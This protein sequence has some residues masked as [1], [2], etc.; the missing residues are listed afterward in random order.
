[1]CKLK[2]LVE[3]EFSQ[4]NWDGRHF[5]INFTK[6]RIPQHPY[7]AS[8]QKLQENE[9]ITFEIQHISLMHKSGVII[10][11]KEVA[12]QSWSTFRRRVVSMSWS[13]SL[14]PTSVAPSRA[15]PRSLCLFSAT[16]QHH[17]RGIRTL[18]HSK[19]TSLLESHR[20]RWCDRGPWTQPSHLP[21]RLVFSEL[22]SSLG[23]MLRILDTDQP[24]W[25]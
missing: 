7:L 9:A 16:Q 19:T 21:Q 3:N 4:V 15:Q 5:Y 22:Q 14:H 20:S 2:L 23:N 6:M 13:S 24:R 18:P 1:M 11:P 25:G 12:H 17:N 10:S 8:V